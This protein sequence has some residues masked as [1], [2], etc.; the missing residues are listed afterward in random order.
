[1][2][3]FFLF[4]LVFLALSAVARRANAEPTSTTVG[5]YVNQVGGIDLKGNNYVVDF[6]VWFR[7]TGRST[8]PV[9]TFEV[10][11]GKVNSK[12]NVIK[13]KLPDGSDYASARVHATVHQL[14]D[15]HHYPFDDHALE[16]AIEDQEVDKTQSVF[17]ADHGNQGY[18]PS[19]AVSGWEMAGFDHHVEDHS[20]ESNYGDPTVGTGNRSIFS[21]F[22][23]RLHAK[24]Q[25]SA[26]FVK[27]AFPLLISVFIAWCAFFVRPKD[28]SPRVSVSVGALF[29]AAAGTVAMNSQLPDI[30]YATTADKTVFL[31]LGMIASSLLMTVTVLALH[32]RGHEATHRKVDR[33]GSIAFP[34][35]FAFLLF[36]VVR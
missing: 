34:A 35:L 3:H 28:A 13:K 21:R 16:I 29:A 9:D 5:I 8:S 15:L 11:D 20:Y 25:G 12:S 24:R 26:R 4:A 17:V 32:Y 19:V 22:V 23:F 27:V 1:M 31:C 10:M 33:I 36:L 7:S 14:W 30:N 6:W 2:R 18:D